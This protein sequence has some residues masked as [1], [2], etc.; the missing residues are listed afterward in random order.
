MRQPGSPGTRGLPSV[1]MLRLN[2]GPFRNLLGACALALLSA[3]G[4]GGGGDSAPSSSATLVG[5]DVQATEEPRFLT[6]GSTTRFVARGNYSDGNN[7]VPLTSVTW[8][9]DAPLVATVAGDGT[10]TGV[11]LGNATITAR[12]G[13]IFGKNT[14]GVTR[15]ATGW[16]QVSVGRDHVLAVKTDGSLWSWG[17][18]SFSGNEFGQLGTGGTTNTLAPTRVGSDTDWASVAA[19]DLRSYAVK[20]NGTLWGWGKNSDNFLGDGS[21]VSP[22]VPTRIGNATTWASVAT[23]WGHTLAIQTDGSLWAWG[24]NFH[25]QLGTGV[26]GDRTT[27]TRV[28]SATNWASVSVGRDHTVAVK[29]DGSLWGWGHSQ[30]GQVGTGVSGSDVFS[31]VYDP[32]RIGTDS[33]WSRAA[34]GSWTTLAVKTDGSLY[35]WGSN[36]FGQLVNGGTTSTDVPVRSGSAN[37]WSEVTAG[38]SYAVLTKADGSLWSTDGGSAAAVR[39]GT[40]TGWRTA[41]VGDYF[42]TLAVD[43]TGAMSA[44]DS[45]TPAS[46]LDYPSGG[47]GTGPS[48]SV[49]A[50]PPPS[51]G[52]GGGSGGGA[53]GL[54]GTWCTNVSGNQNCW[55]FDND[56]GSSNGKF[57]QQSINQYTGTLTNTMTWSVNA[58]ARTLT[59]KFTRSTLTNSA[60]AYDEAVSVGPYTFGYTLTPTAFTF[61]GITFQKR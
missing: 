17:T 48:P 7:G 50:P 4:G 29:S 38:Y 3:C 53:T 26:A 46:I 23:K 51:G 60:Y 15:V 42:T 31:I 20:S 40:A 37:D 2:I 27:P 16:R 33:N 6:A 14:L 44:L 61:Q 41:A 18:S 8:S 19:G 30:N 32:T 49:V 36:T 1:D 35:G 28:G 10:V 55:V 45:S 5:I 43:A 13:T 11:A 52:S 34:A 47:T 22:G 58:S 25:F 21:G 54:A 9:S 39:L 12:V 59:Y 57:Y 24:N 56:S